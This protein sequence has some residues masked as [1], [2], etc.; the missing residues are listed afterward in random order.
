MGIPPVDQQ[1][2]IDQ[3]ALCARL[4]NICVKYLNFPEFGGGVCPES[5]KIHSIERPRYWRAT[6]KKDC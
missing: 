5:R 3:S 1:F 2:M 4:A 6:T